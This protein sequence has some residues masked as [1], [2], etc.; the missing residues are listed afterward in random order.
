MMMS[1][2]IAS[3]CAALAA[4]GA[5]SDACNKAAEAGLKQQGTYQLVDKYEENFNAYAVQEGN[6]YF[7]KG[8]MAAIG[9]AG[10]TYKTY[11]SKS[12]NFKLPTL[13]VCD[14]ANNTITPTTYTINLQWHT[15][16]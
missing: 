3:F 10:F 15:P 2:A 7:G 16:W 14:S 11:K 4:N 6:H 13:G 12:L 9:A 1:S 5:Y 8:G